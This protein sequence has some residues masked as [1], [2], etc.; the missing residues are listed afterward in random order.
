[1]LL[2]VVLLPDSGRTANQ[3]KY[4]STVPDTELRTTITDCIK[5]NNCHF[6]TSK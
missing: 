2:G 1:M 3:L 6:S 4:I 5:L